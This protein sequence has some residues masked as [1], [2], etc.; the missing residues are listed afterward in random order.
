MVY[1]Y[2]EILENSKKKVMRVPL[3]LDPP[4]HHIVVLHMQLDV[5]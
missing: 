4:V 3:P 2:Q 5:S 1:M